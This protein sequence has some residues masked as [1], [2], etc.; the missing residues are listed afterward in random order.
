MPSLSDVSP[1]TVGMVP[2]SKLSL[3]P[4]QIRTDKG[5]VGELAA[6]ITEA[7]VQSPLLVCPNPE[8]PGGFWVIDGSRRLA[9]L[10]LAEI[11]RAPVRIL[12][13]PEDIRGA[14]CA[15]MIANFHRKQLTPVEMAKAIGKLRDRENMTV[16]NIAR[17][18]GLSQATVYYHLH[19]LRADAATLARIEAGQVTAGAVHE[20]ISA[21]QGQQAHADAA[22]KRAYT[23]R[24]NR[25]ALAAKKANAYFNATHRLSPLAAQLC[26]DGG[27]QAS[28]RIGKVACGPHWEQAI[29]QDA[30]SGRPGLTPAFATGVR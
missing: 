24:T 18:T 7:S 30:L 17:K 21:T 26:R 6:S 14:I 22:N 5:D 15:M 4:D 23:K 28:E 29:A 27:C 1:M 19:L 9:A 16:P 3:H 13:R 11:T 20:A 25:P 2:V 8:K 12:L 10:E